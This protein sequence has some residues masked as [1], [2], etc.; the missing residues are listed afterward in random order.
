MGG[1]IRSFIK[2][3]MGPWAYVAAA[4]AAVV[5]WLRRGGT[6]ASS[7]IVNAKLSP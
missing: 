6:A 4:R 5:P 2:I 3:Y 7:K 1:F